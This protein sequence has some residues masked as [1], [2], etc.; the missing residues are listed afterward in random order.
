VVAA[1]TAVALVATGGG[2]NVSTGQREPA[3]T[4]VQEVLVSGRGHFDL[5]RPPSREE[6]GLPANKTDVTYEREDHTP[7]EV[8]VDLPEGKKLDVQARLL[9]FDALA[10]PDPRTA[11]PT[12]LDIHYL[13]TWKVGPTSSP[14]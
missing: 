2:C 10:E 3:S 6:A 12:T 7:F 14:S 13:L 5:T 11:P 1:L 8:L 9:T 4:K